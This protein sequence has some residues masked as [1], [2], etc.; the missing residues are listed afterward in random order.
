[1]THMTSDAEISLEQFENDPKLAE[2]EE[3]LSRFNI[4]EAL[5]VVRRELCHSDFLAF[6]LRPLMTAVRNEDIDV[7]PL[8]L[9]F[10]VCPRFPFAWMIYR[11][12]QIKCAQ[13]APKKNV[14]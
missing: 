7:M 1:M 13:K 5:G 2:V 4:F 12:R 14:P 6:L 10:C 3:C 9:N 8:S 11:T